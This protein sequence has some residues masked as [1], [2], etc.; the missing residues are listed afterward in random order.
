MPP[1]LLCCPNMLVLQPGCSLHAPILFLIYMWRE[2]N[3]DNDNNLQVK[4]DALTIGHHAR[5]FLVHFKHLRSKRFQEVN[6]IC[7][8]L[9]RARFFRI[10]IAFYELLNTGTHSNSVFHILL[11]LSCTFDMDV[12]CT[13]RKVVLTWKSKNNKFGSFLGKIS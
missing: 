11:H 5:V 8:N 1:K 9:G 3:E 7:I 2:V 13:G 4:M 10:F 6:K 12:G